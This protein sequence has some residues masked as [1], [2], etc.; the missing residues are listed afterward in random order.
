MPSETSMGGER[1]SFGE[2]HWSLLLE[3]RDPSSPEYARH[4]DEL[5]HAYWKPVY[6]SIRI[7]W[8]KS[9]DEAKDLT[10]EFLARLVEKEYWPHLSPDRGSF[11]GYLKTALR[12]FL[13]DAAKAERVRR[14]RQG[15]RLFRFEDAEEEWKRF[16]PESPEADPEEVFERSWTRE[17]V[18]EGLRVLEERLGTSVV[19]EVFRLY[20]RDAW[21][22]AGD[23]A[24]NSAAERLSY[25]AIAEK[26]CLRESDVKLHLRS[27]RGMLRSILLDI[28]RRFAASEKEAEEELRRVLP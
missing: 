16:D 10:Q 9:V 25:E 27:A 2:T 7:G 26:L 15:R 5:I 13:I 14:P 6:Y 4:L 20:Y 18:R 22:C 8:R 17:V 12:H 21:E 19:L 3:L 28:V 24:S 1:R 23:S 11:R